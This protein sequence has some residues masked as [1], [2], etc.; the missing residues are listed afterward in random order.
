[1][2]EK[3]K[4]K[5]Q[6]RRPRCMSDSVNSMRLGAKERFATQMSDQDHPLEAAAYNP[7]RR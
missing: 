1:M 6:S 3:K 5:N 4:T 2:T 7:Y